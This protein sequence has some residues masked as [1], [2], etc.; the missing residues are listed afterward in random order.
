MIQWVARP[1][2]WLVQLP[3][4]LRRPRTTVG[5]RAVVCR[6]H[7]MDDLMARFGAGAMWP[8]AA[9]MAAAAADEVPEE[10]QVCCPGCGRQVYRL[11]RESYTITGNR[12]FLSMAQLVTFTACCG[13]HGGLSEGVW[14]RAG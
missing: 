8:I 13:W 12:D 10:W 2:D 14:L 11:G 4:R 3:T 7:G 1:V 9:S 5:V 6:P